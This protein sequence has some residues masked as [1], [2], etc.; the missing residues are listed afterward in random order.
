MIANRMDQQDSSGFA[1]NRKVASGGK[2]F[3]GT[4]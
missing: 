3:G 4:D 1:A 2:N